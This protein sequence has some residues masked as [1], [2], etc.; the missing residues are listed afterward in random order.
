MFNF[1]KMLNMC[2]LTR[3]FKIIYFDASKMILLYFFKDLLSI[4]VFLFCTIIDGIE[5]IKIEIK[6]KI[7]KFIVFNYICDKTARIFLSRFLLKTFVNF[8]LT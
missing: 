6:N 1:A 4:I 7:V 5:T 3:K 8:K 2:D